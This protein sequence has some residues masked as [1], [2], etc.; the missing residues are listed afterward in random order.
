MK[1]IEATDAAEGG[2]PLNGC[3]AI[4]SISLPKAHRIISLCQNDIPNIAFQN[5][6]YSPLKPALQTQFAPVDAQRNKEKILLI[7]L[8][9]L[10]GQVLEGR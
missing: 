7:V 3:E 6:L 4:H 2:G 1:A 8:S 5:F 10:I 9:Q